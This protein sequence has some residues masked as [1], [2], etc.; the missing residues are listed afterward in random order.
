MS[1]IKTQLSVLFFI[2]ALASFK[3]RIFS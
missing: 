2:T 1:L 3:M